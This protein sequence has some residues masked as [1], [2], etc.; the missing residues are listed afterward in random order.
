M[1]QRSNRRAAALAA[2][3]ALA[4]PMKSPAAPAAAPK[5]GPTATAGAT[6]PPPRLGAI[7]RNFV[8]FAASS[9]MAEVDASRLA[10]DRSG[11]RDVRA[12]AQHMIDEHAKANEEL[13][14]LA[15]TLG[16]VEE[17]SVALPRHTAGL[18]RLRALN[19]FE[20]DREYTAQVGVASHLETVAVFEKG[21]RQLGHPQLKALASLRL[22]ELRQHLKA[23]E[24]LA[25]SVAVPVERMKEAT[26]PPDI[27]LRTGFLS[28][29]TGSGDIATN[30][31]EP[32]GRG[33]RAGGGN[34][35]TASGSRSRSPTG[36]SPGATGAGK[37][38]SASNLPSSS[39][40][41]R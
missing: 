16:L 4:M 21:A 2:V 38:G 8:I 15:K 12:F 5:A 25:K 39:A 23:A 14:S 34:G 29:T 17:A 28:A 11:N 37:G 6:K 40:A 24:M 13:K 26:L 32:P 30:D 18:D 1:R 41:G 22:P 3:L 33:P 9:G 36:P 10:L 20:F 7:D 19:G 31:V 35:G 27:N